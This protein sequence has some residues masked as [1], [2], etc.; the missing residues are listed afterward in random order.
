MKPSLT[1][2]F[3]CVLLAAQCACGQESLLQRLDDSLSYQSP[4]GFF[5]TDLSGLVDV[6]GYFIDQRPPGLLFGQDDRLNPRLSLF[7][8]THFGEHF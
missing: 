8:D 5:R 2:S 6:D 3:A 1:S 4:K 7:L